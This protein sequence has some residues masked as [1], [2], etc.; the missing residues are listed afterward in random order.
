[1][2]ARLALRSRPLGPE[3]LEVGVDFFLREAFQSLFQRQTFES[4]FWGQFWE[5]FQD[6]IAP[7]V[8]HR[9][10][11]GNSL[12]SI[13]QYQLIYDRARVS[14]ALLVMFLPVAPPV[15]RP[16]EQ[17]QHRVWL[18][19]RQLAGHD[20]ADHVAAPPAVVDAGE[21]LLQEHRA[22][23]VVRVAAAYSIQAKLD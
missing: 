13:A 23:Q 15:R 16:A 21:K 18:G 10:R 14:R 5:M 2:P 12:D 8:L 20:H 7:E 1:F 3:S 19:P 11:H 4:F 22:C 6:V 9:V 17:V